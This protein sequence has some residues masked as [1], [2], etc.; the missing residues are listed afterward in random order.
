MSLFF[1]TIITLFIFISTIL[2][3]NPNIICKMMQKDITCAKKIVEVPKKCCAARKEKKTESDC[4]H[5]SKSSKC[6]LSKPE[7]FKKC[8]KCIF[9]QPIKSAV[10]SEHKL[11]VN[12]KTITLFCNIEINT[13]DKYLNNYIKTSIPIGIHRTIPSTILLL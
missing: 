1:H 11:T 13:T 2:S 7:K 5:N 3:S 9:S 6:D 8:Y 10:L 12:L 4:S